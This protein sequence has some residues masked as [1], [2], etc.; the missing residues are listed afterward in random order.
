MRGWT[1]RNE[2][3]AC[4]KLAHFF[5]H[6][7]LLRDFCH[8]LKAIVYAKVKTDPIDSDTLAVLCFTSNRHPVPGSGLSPSTAPAGW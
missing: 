8:R 7:R 4:A 5:A 6:A 2:Q 1:V 3:D